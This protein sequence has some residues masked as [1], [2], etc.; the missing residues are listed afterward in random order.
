[1]ITKADSVENAKKSIMEIG[2]YFIDMSDKLYGDLQDVT[3]I[4]INIKM[5]PL[6]PTTFKVTKKYTPR[7]I[8]SEEK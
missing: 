7:K 4:D 1:M 8:E 3:E 5:S 2:Q 6:E